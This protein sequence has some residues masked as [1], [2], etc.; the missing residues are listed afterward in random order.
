MTGW[1]RTCEA[2]LGQAGLHLEGVGPRSSGK[3]IRRI[4]ATL[5]PPTF[6]AATL[7]PSP[8]SSS[9]PPPRSP[10]GQEINFGSIS[11]FQE[12]KLEASLEGAS[13]V[14]T[15]RLSEDFVEKKSTTVNSKGKFLLQ[16]SS[17]ASRQ[18]EK[19]NPLKQWWCCHTARMVA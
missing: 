17:K 5:I 19:W 10:P 1:Q 14:S 6:V 11:S 15:L 16:A 3:K 13:L 8:S 9:P 12:L 4:S 18:L 2:H 7:T